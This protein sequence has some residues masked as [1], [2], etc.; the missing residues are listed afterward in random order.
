MAWIIRKSVDEKS[1]G[2][3]TGLGNP[4]LNKGSTGNGF[5]HEFESNAFGKLDRIVFVLS[6]RCLVT[7]WANPIS[8]I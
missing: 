5:A 8:T 3:G 2:R 6:S 1:L 4:S 7:A